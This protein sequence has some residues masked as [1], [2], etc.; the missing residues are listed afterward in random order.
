MLLNN[1]VTQRTTTVFSVFMGKMITTALKVPVHRFIAWRL[2][3][4]YRKRFFLRKFLTWQHWAVSD[5]WKV[6]Q[7]HLANP[8]PC[9]PRLH[10]H[11]VSWRQI[12]CNRPTSRLACVQR[13]LSFLTRHEGS[14]LVNMALS[15]YILWQWQRV[16]RS[17]LNVW[18]SVSRTYNWLSWACLYVISC[19]FYS[20]VEK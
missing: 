12:L 4:S 1:Y 7:W 10:S 5:I 18:F 20:K 6:S 17:M 16:T 14:F 8:G 3:I 19:W 2:L 11:M 9:R 13:R 15:L